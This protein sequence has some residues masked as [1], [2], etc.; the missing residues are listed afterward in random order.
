MY[1]IGGIHGNEPEG[2]FAA[3]NLANQSGRTSPPVTVRIIDDANP[4]GTRAGTRGNARGR[5]L[6][7]NWPATNFAGGARRPDPLSEPETRALHRDIDEFAPDLIV[8]FHSISSGPFV[9]FDGPAGEYAAA[10]ADAAREIDSRWRV[11]PQMGYRT[12][13]SMGSYFGI[14]R[15]IPILT[16]EFARGQDAASA[17]AAAIAGLKAVV[18][19]LGNQTRQVTRTPPI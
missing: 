8:V 7:R 12:P 14:D 1:V 17:S 11:V 2:L 4:D 10:F 19:R 15:S 5:D 18:E 6:N 9:N 13:G 16:I 3:T